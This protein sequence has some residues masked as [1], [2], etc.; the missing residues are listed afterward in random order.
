MDADRRT[1]PDNSH[2]I[3]SK[4][5]NEIHGIIHKVPSSVRAEGDQICVTLGNSEIRMGYEDGIK[6]SNWIRIASKEAKRNAGDTSRHWSVI[7][8]ADDAQRA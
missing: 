7:A 5:P 8:Q 3:V 4:F 2:A 6:L 1:G